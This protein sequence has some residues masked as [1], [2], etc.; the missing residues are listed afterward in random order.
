MQKHTHVY[1][2][3]HYKYLESNIFECTMPRQS[4]SECTLIGTRSINLEHKPG[5]INFNGYNTGSEM[6]VRT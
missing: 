6:Y 2:D 4:F 1:L 3:L 5:S